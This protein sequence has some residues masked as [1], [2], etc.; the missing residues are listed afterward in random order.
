MTPF[1]LGEEEVVLGFALIGIR[2]STPANR[3]E[4]LRELDAARARTA[5]AMLFVTEAVADLI[6]SEIRDAMLGGTVIQI[7]PGVRPA[8]AVAED[9]QAALLAALGIKL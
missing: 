1:V 3:E 9:S 2:G 6:R 4:A 5:Q 7:I 8:R